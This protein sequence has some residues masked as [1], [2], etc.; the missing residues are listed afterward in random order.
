MDQRARSI[1]QARAKKQGINCKKWFS[2]RG[3]SSGKG[4]LQPE[5]IA[6]QLD[7]EIQSCTRF[8]NVLYLDSCSFL[9]CMYGFC[10]ATIGGQSQRSPLVTGV[11]VVVVS[12]VS[13][14]QT[15]CF[16]GRSWFSSGWWMRSHPL[17]RQISWP[18]VLLV[19]LEVLVLLPPIVV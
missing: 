11:D 19:L 13:R 1:L 12:L 2:P 18:S 16:P 15:R 9:S 7:I 10:Q 14:S 4:T 8:D 5:I 17:C 3:T 6:V